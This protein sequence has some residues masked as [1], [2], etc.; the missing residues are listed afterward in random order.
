MYFQFKSIVTQKAVLESFSPL[1]L[2]VIPSFEKMKRDIPHF[3]EPN[4]VD[5]FNQL[6]ESHYFLKISLSIFIVLGS[7]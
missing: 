7:L 1:K 6:V 5:A 4:E 3:V 2:E